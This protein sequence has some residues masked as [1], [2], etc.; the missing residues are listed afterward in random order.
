MT[1]LLILINL[2]ALHLFSCLPGHLLSEPTHCSS[3]QTLAVVDRVPLLV[4]QWVIQLSPRLYLIRSY[5]IFSKTLLTQNNWITLNI[6]LFVSV[7]YLVQ[8]FLISSQ[9]SQRFSPF[10]VLQGGLRDFGNVASGFSLWCTAGWPQ[11]FCRMSCDWHHVLI[12]FCAD[13]CRSMY[14]IVLCRSM[15]WSLWIYVLI[16]ADQLLL[17][18]SRKIVA[19]SG[20]RPSLPLGSWVS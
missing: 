12:T 9:W 7:F 6:L 18:C 8:N 17:Y 15:S 13:P 3:Q 4:M 1:Q 16:F 11:G 2:L 10:G 14:S 19:D 20:S 5:I